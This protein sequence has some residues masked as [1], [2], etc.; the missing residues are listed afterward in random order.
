MAIWGDFQGLTRVTRGGRGLKELENWGDVIYG[1]SLTY[2]AFTLIL[3]HM[4]S[5]QLQR[6]TGKSIEIR[7]K[8][9]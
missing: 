2:Q 9:A 4:Y 1:W 5:M 6:K 3:L 7:Y 8:I